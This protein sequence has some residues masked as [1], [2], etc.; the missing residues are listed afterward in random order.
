MNS[1]IQSGQLLDSLNSV[2][3]A[4]GAG[5][6]DPFSQ[7]KWRRWEA[8]WV[9]NLGDIRVCGQPIII[10]WYLELAKANVQEWPSVPVCLR[11]NFVFM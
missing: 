2:N 7:E 11:L 1:R 3:S 5:P 4:A 10:G 6:A 9:R 8:G